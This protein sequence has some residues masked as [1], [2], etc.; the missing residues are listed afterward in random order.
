MCGSLAQ[1]ASQ[2]ST[3]GVRGLVRDADGPSSGA[4]VRLTKEDTQI[5]RRAVT[6][7]QGQFVFLAVPPGTYTLRISLQGFQTVVRRAVEIATQDFVTLDVLLESGPPGARPM[8]ATGTPLTTTANASVG[9]ALEGAMLDGFPSPNRNPFTLGLTV[10]TV[11]SGA[12]P[13]RTLQREQTESSRVSIGGGIQ[14]NTYVLDGLPIS[15]LRGRALLSPTLESLEDVRIHVHAYDAEVSRTGGGV[16]NATA[17]AGTNVFH[18]SGLFQTRPV[19]GQSLSF[20]AVQRELTKD[21]VGLTGSVHRVY[22]GGVGGPLWRDHTFF[23]AA[24][25]SYRASRPESLEE[26][27]PSALQR[28]GDFS[29]TSVNGSAV[30]IFNPFCREGVASARC[31]ATGPSGTLENPEFAGAVIPSFALNPVAR[32]MAAAWPLSTR[33]NEDTEPNAAGDTAATD[34]ADQLS[35]KIEHTIRDGWTLGGLVTST[36]TRDAVAV[37]RWSSRSA[38]APD[39]SLQSAR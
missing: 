2:P 12:D 22:G 34:E 25:E 1:A 13:R 26:L 7:A 21:D 37:H 14:A 20:F 24:A 38:D 11:V 33:G 4:T 36:E 9:T 6:D 30:R 3:G 31:P 8:V 23:W 28:V 17:R 27:W 18:G 29:T 10:P 32:A 16:F 5:V 15:D 39:R 35:F 19:W